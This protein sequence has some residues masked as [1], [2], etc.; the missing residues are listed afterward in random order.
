MGVDEAT[1]IAMDLVF[2]WRTAVLTVAAAILLPLAVG[3]SASFHNRL[4]ARALA[5]LLLM[6]SWG[7]YDSKWDWRGWLDQAVDRLVTA[8]VPRLVVDLRANERGGG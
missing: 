5:A 7:L 8:R 2:G 4:A 1:L 3:L 6:P